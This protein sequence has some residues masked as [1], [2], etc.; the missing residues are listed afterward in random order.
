MNLKPKRKPSPKQSFISKFVKSETI[1]WPR[2]MKIANGLW[3][4][5]PDPLFWPQFILTFQLNSLAWLINGDGEQELIRQWN[6]YQ[7]DK[8]RK[9]T[10]IDKTNYEIGSIR[11][12]SLDFKPK[13]M[14]DW[15][16]K[17]ENLTKLI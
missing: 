14:K 7:L 8:R 1:N 9:S 4:K 15:M 5:Y 17:D 2:E 11:Q 10:M 6:Y 3:K 16:K 12:E 13:T